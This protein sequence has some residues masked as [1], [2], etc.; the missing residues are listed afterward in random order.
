MVGTE[1]EMF[2]RRSQCHRTKH[3]HSFHGRCRWE[4]SFCFFGVF[5]AVVLEA[6]GITTVVAQ[7]KIHILL[8]RVFPN[9]GI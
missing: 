3:D 5:S 9:E 1:T 4:T 8:V 6:I 2:R 7:I